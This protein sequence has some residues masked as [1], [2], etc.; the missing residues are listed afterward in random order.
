MT[1]KFNSTMINNQLIK[2][3]CSLSFDNVATFG[4][5]FASTII[6]ITRVRENILLFHSYVKVKKKKKG[7][8]HIFPYSDML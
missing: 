7:P 8:V 4:I 2:R 5:Q 6:N 1:N 3:H